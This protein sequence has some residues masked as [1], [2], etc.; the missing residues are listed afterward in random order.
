MLSSGQELLVIQRAPAPHDTGCRDRILLN[1]R[2]LL[3]SRTIGWIRHDHLCWTVSSMLNACQH[4]NL[5]PRCW[6]RET[7]GLAMMKTWSRSW[8][9]LAWHLKCT[10]CVPLRQLNCR[11]AKPT[12][13]KRQPAKQLKRPKGLPLHGAR[14]Y[15]GMTPSRLGND[16]VPLYAPLLPSPQQTHHTSLALSLCICLSPCACNYASQPARCY[17]YTRAADVHR[18]L[19]LSTAG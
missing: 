19:Q 1:R 9:R 18:Q 17:I 10:L 6:C 15:G 16:A 11:G 2:S 7:S 13:P 8:M 3:R 5:S 12:T 4:W 14:Q